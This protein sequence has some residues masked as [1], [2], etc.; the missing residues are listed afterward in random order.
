MSQDVFDTHMPT[1]P[2]AKQVSDAL[3]F[4]SVHPTIRDQLHSTPSLEGYGWKLKPRTRQAVS[5][6]L[7]E[8]LAIA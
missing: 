4:F 8:I 2:D 3:K 5:S 6:C 7:A 1:Q